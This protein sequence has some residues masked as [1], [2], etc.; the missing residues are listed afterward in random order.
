MA[1]IVEPFIKATII[2]KAEFVGTIM[3]LCIEKRGMLTN[4][5]YW[6]QDRVELTFDM[7]MAEVVFDF[8]DKLKTISKGYA[9]FDYYPTDYVKS[10]L[11]KLDILLNAEQVDALSALVHS[12]NPHNLGK[13]ICVKLKELIPW[14]QFEIP[15]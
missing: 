9:S 14:Q 7:P 13:K 8:Y 5:V 12:S 11:F 10:D 15:I 4:Q 2:T 3:T 6:T 1:Y